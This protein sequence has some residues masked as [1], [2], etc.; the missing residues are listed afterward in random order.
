MSLDVI[1]TWTLEMYPTNCR[2]EAMG[3][4]QFVNKLGAASAP[5]VSKGL[6]SIHPVAPFIMM[7]VVGI[8]ASAL[9]I[10]LPETRGVCMCD[11]GDEMVDVE[12]DE[13]MLINNSEQSVVNAAKSV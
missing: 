1:Y 4:Q 8:L 6:K 11:T 2:A 13:L 12:K 5:W 7:S 10:L 9:A 3:F